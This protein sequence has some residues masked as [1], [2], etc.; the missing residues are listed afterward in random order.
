M[1]SQ[2]QCASDG[3]FNYIVFYCDCQNFRILGYAVL[4]TWLLALFYMLGNPAADYFCCS[5]QK[6]SSL[7]NLPPTVAGV[8]LLP[9]GNGAPDVFAS[10]AI[11]VDTDAGEVKAGCCDAIA[12]SQRGEED[13][14]IYNSLLDIE[15]ES[16][17]PHLH[18]TL[19]QWMWASNVA[20]YSNQTLRINE[21]DR[22]RHLWG[23]T[24]EVTDIDD[25]SLIS[26]LKYFLCWRCL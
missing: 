26:C 6:L 2:P 20:I 3:F 14:S 21:L 24:D 17:P 13:E 4:G 5:L 15:S 25:R 18:T 8:S 16:D 23:W 22:P 19:P 12:S 11:F 10:I 9:L 7:S 1:Q